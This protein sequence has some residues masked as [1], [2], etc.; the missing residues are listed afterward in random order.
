MGY[1]YMYLK[2]IQANASLLLPTS[3]IPVLCHFPLKENF[4]M[5][6]FEVLIIHLSSKELCEN[7]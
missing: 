4:S 1:I 3:A 2:N 7:L 6:F 5:I